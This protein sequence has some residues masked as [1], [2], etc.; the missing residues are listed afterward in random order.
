MPI[1]SW[2]IDMTE[3]GSF[4]SLEAGGDALPSERIRAGVDRV[5]IDDFRRTTDVAGERFMER[6]F[7][8]DEVAFCAGRVERLA[9]RFAA[10][11]AVAK[12]LGT[13]FRNL[14]WSEIEIISAPHG[15]PRV[16]LH[17]RA[18]EL[19]DALGIT[20]I[21]VSLT[22]STKTAEAF[23]VALCRDLQ[24]QQPL[25]RETNHG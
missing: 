2:R 6:I 4:S 12:L 9:V 25:V 5:E 1:G 16:R 20:S 22:H 15:E 10:K 24:S 14:G 13:G 21:A 17:G 18:Q 19:A 7:T 3:I 8:S 23:V 11:E